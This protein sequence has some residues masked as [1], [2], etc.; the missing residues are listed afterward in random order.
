MDKGKIQDNGDK[1]RELLKLVNWFAETILLDDNQLEA[2]HIFR[3]L[4]DLKKNQNDDLE[5]NMYK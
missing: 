4:V 2:L 5:N 3:F 1:L